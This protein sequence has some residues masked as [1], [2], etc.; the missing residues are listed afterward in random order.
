MLKIIF[1]I[2]AF[3]AFLSANPTTEKN[4]NIQVSDKEVQSFTNAST[5]ISAI[6][7]KIQKKMQSKHSEKSQPLS[8][9]QVK[10]YNNDFT[11]QAKQIIE[12]NGLTIEKYNLLTKLYQNS[13]KFKVR[14]QKL[15]TK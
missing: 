10:K 14:V 5:Q 8:K 15:L 13:E 4:K 9:E 2:I 7:T 1:S 3:C 11:S 12:K 6:K